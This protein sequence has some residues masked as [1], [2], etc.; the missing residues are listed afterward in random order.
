MPPCCRQWD[1][2]VR[3]KRSRMSNLDLP[4]VFH[5]SSAFLAPE[6]LSSPH[7]LAPTSTTAAHRIN[8]LNFL[9]Q[10]KPL[11]F[12]HIQC[13]RSLSPSANSPIDADSVTRQ[14]IPSYRR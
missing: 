12:F 10:I 2:Y 14:K 4:R 11:K 1:E 9:Y 6:P 3:V 13:R 7:R 5:S 8:I